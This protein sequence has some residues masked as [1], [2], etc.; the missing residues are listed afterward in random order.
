[1]G[2]RVLIGVGAVVAVAVVLVGVVL[3]V[4]VVVVV[5]ISGDKLAP[6][7]ACNLTSSCLAELGSGSLASILG[8]NFSSQE[9]PLRVLSAERKQLGA[10]LIHVSATDLASLTM[11]ELKG[12][13]WVGFL[14]NRVGLSD[15]SDLPNW[16][17]FY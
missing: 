5:E 14:V 10:V 9:V 4:V 1:M 17:S 15:L 2:Q 6:S 3:V 12:L 7:E 16:V 8:G 11:E 13:K